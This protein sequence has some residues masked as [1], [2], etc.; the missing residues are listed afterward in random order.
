MTALTKVITDQIKTQFKAAVHRFLGLQ[1][2]QNACFEI[3]LS[4]CI[5]TNICTHKEGVSACIS[6]F[7]CEDVGGGDS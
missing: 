3:D 4:L 5:I 1:I 2:I 7:A 6:Y